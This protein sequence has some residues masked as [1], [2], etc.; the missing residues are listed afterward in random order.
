VLHISIENHWK[1]FKTEPVHNDFNFLVVQDS[2][3]AFLF[4]F[5]FIEQI[6]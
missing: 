5:N 3:N 4:Q 6:P 1:H 2:E